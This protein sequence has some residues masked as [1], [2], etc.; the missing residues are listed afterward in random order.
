[1]SATYSVILIIVSVVG[2]IRMSRIHAESKAYEQ[3]Q[4]REMVERTLAALDAAENQDPAFVA[5][6]RSLQSIL[7]PKAWAMRVGALAAQSNF[8]A[9]AKAAVR[10]ALRPGPVEALA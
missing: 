2:L 5:E 6:A 1:M 9:D 10:R 7:V 3:H 8:D 4:E